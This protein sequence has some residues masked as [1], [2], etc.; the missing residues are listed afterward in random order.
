MSN[1][2]IG[3][4]VVC[5]KSGDDLTEGK[6]YS[7]EGLRNGI[8]KCSSVLLD[9]GVSTNEKR[10]NCPRHGRDFN[11]NGKA[12]FV[13]RLFAPIEEADITELLEILNEEKI[14]K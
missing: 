4:R 3:Q 13:E 2:Y 5:L 9:V 1:W 11:N 12:W 8:C 14:T 7:I 10:S 6:V